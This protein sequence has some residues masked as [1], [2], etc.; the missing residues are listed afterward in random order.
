MEQM[1]RTLE[2][3]IQVYCNYG[4]DNWDEL[5]P[6]A[7]F[8]NNNAHSATTGITPFY[9]NKGYHQNFTVHLEC[10][11]TSACACNIVTDLDELHQELKQHIADAQ[12][13]YQHSADSRRSLALEFKIGSQAFVKAQFFHM[14]RPSK[15]LSKKFLGPYKINAQPGSH[16]VTL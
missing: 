11:P 5:L 16:S 14:T 8:A 7:E 10:D 4:Q 15:K 1:N 12:H 6:L 2:Q 9:A 3:Y 13:H